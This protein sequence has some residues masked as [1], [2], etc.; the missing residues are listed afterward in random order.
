MFT[1]KRYLHWRTVVSVS[2]LLFIWS[3]SA[4]TFLATDFVVTR[5]WARSMLF[6]P[7]VPMV[8]A[9]SII[10]PHFA[11]SQQRKDGEYLSLIFSRPVPR[12]SY[13]ITKWLSGVIFTLAIVFIQCIIA[14]TFASFF[15]RQPQD[16][17]DGYS[18]ADT[19]LNAFSYTALLVLISS[20]PSPWG[21]WIFSW[22]WVCC[23]F[24]TMGV[25]TMSFITS[26]SV[27]ELSRS[28]TTASQ[29]LF[30]F[31][32]AGFDSYH[33]VQ[34]SKLPLVDIVIYISNLVLYLTL[35]VFIMNRREFFYAND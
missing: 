6:G 22:F 32:T 16:I 33:V 1:I 2:S 15:G 30:S 12:W 11:N 24:I 8:V 13:V 26:L 19:I 10:S 18:I 17:V 14:F 23:V 20:L 27:D 31:F 28:I 25:G 7:F 21:Y 3:V 4:G 34:S 35:S 29:L 9:L 5:E